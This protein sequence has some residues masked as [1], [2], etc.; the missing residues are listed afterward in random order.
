M[1][2]EVT[3]LLC[4]SLLGLACLAGLVLAGCDGGQRGSVPSSSNASTVVPVT[5]V[6]K[7]ASVPAEA[8]AVERT[9]EL[10]RIERQAN[11]TPVTLATRRLEDASC[12]DGVIVL[13]TSQETIYAARSCDGFWDAEARELFVGHDVALVLELT[14]ERW[15]VLVNAVDGAQAEF[16][17]G[18]IWVQRR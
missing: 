5:P 13:T 8:E 18:G 16:T 3:P 6:P 17:V 2:P 4:P 11:R 1:R 14:E 10:G 7:P 15:R 12:A 9:E